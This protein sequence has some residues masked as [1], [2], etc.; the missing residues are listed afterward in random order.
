MKIVYYEEDDTLFIEF[1]KDA[2]VFRAK[3]TTHSV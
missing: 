3:V 1:S 2:C